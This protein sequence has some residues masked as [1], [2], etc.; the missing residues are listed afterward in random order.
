MAEV[1]R[2]INEVNSTAPPAAHER[3]LSTELVA[4]NIQGF[5]GSRSIVKTTVLPNVSDPNRLL[6]PP[7][8]TNMAAAMATAF[9]PAYD[10]RFSA[11]WHEAATEE[12]QR[13]RVIQEQ[14]VKEEEE[15][16]FA[17]QADYHARVAG[18]T[19]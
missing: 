8:Q 13:R 12:D 5:G 2:S 10:K 14:R 11:R 19:K 1:D 16:K 17:A 18:W 15:Q 9:M 6:W 7:P 4:R 3:L